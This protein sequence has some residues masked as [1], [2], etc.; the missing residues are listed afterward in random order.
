MPSTTSSQSYLG[1]QQLT[2]HYSSSLR[3]ANAL[4]TESIEMSLIRANVSAYNASTPGGI[5][6]DAPSAAA[7]NTYNYCSAPRVSVE[8]YD[9]PV[10]ASTTTEGEESAQLKHVI[11][12]QRHEKRT[13]DNLVPE[14]ENA[15]NPTA[16]WDCVSAALLAPLLRLRWHDIYPCGIPTVRRAI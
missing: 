12:V 11:Y 1:H 7:W 16:G 15:F 2:W 10:Q 3:S 13:P 4:S 6:T 9:P 8:H 14:R 5:Y